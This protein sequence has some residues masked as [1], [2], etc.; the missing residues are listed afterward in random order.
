MA[1]PTGA[2]YKMKKILREAD[3]PFF[4]DDDLEFYLAENAGDINAALYQT[5]IIKSE[6]TAIH[7]TGWTSADTSNYYKRL[8]ARY[9]PQNSGVLKT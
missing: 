7:L 6:D 1:A 4:S 9:R 2:L 3:V 8:A 5:L